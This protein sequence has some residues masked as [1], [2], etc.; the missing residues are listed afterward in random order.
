M[1]FRSWLKLLAATTMAAAVVGAGQLGIAYGLGMVRLDQTLEVTQRDQWTAQLA[2][3]AWITMTAAALGAVVA[4][5]LRPRWSPRPVGAAGSLAMG[6]AAGVG[7]LAVLPLT[8]QPARAA[9]VAGVQPV[10]VIGICAV[11]AA[12]V[13]IFAAAAAAAKPVARWSVATL[14]VVVWVVA[15]ISVVPSLLPGQS[16]VAARLGVLE[17]RLI[18]AAATEHTP[19]VTM[20]VLALLTGL[21]LGLV[22]RSRKLSTLAVALSGLTGP[23]LLTVAYL[24]AGPGSAA[25]FEL[26]PYWA[27]MTAAGAG[28]LGSV[29]AAIVRGGGSEPAPAAEPDAP[30]DDSPA[31]AK[32]EPVSGRASLPRRDV[33]VQSAIAAAAAAAAQRPEEQLRPSDTGVFAVGAGDRPHPLQ[34]LA[35]ASPGATYTSGAASADAE[36]RF[37]GQQ[38]A[39][40]GA[41]LRRGWRTRRGTPEAPAPSPALTGD[42]GSF[43]GFTAGHPRVASRAPLTPEPTPI[44]APLP[45]PQPIAP[46]PVAPAPAQRGAMGGR[47][48][49]DYVDWV[50]GLGN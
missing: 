43:N 3:V 5:G 20:P 50:N 22:A 17:G 21:I 19:F 45:Q 12:A 32:P 39:K 42:S 6:L 35:A 28:V 36:P 44:S 15:L 29:L 16:P 47:K 26:S 11:L 48:E 9:Q 49:E 1:A 14:S 25:G 46:P 33:P 38:P 30:A 37:S 23:V 7:A 41:G 34:D 18:P 4:T 31:D 24:I 8:M 40:R 13:G 27:A 10:V 2:W